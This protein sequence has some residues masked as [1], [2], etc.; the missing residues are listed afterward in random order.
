MTTAALDDRSEPFATDP[1]PDRITMVEPRTDLRGWPAK[2]RVGEPT[3]VTASITNTTPLTYGLTTP[4]LSLYRRGNEQVT[5]EVRDGAQ[6]RPVQLFNRYH[7]LYAA[8]YPTLKP[9][10]VYTATLRV[11]FQD[12]A[13]VGEEGYVYH[14]VS[15]AYDQPITAVIL[16]F[17]LTA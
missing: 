3:E 6:W 13:A 15:T 16:P 5:V 1:E 9:G 4:S 17:T 12:D 10:E 7:W 14:M 11:T 2:F 8:N